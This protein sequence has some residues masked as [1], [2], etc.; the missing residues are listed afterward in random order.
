MLCAVGSGE[1][2]S[3]NARGSIGRAVVWVRD[4]PL[5]QLAAWLGALA[6]ALTAPFGGWADASHPPMT[7]V[8][9]DQVVKT[10]PIDVTITR[11]R[12]NT[13]PGETFAAMDDGQYL[14][15]FGTARGT[16]KTTLTNGE[17]ADAIRL[18]G[19]PGLEDLLH[20]RL[21]AGHEVDVGQAHGLCGRGLDVDDGVGPRPDLQVAWVWRQQQRPTEQ[22]RRA[23]QGF[24]WRQRSL[25]DYTGWLDP[26]PTAHLRLPVEVDPVGQAG[27]HTEPRGIAHAGGDVM[28]AADVCAVGSGRAAAWAPE[29]SSWPAWPWDESSPIVSRRRS[30]I[31]KPIER[32]GVIGAPIALRIGDVTVT[33][34][35][36][37]TSWASV[38]EGKRTQGVWLAA[39][40]DLLPSRRESGL[41]YAAVRDSSGHVWEL[42]RGESTC[43]AP[44]AGVPMH[45]Q[46]LIELPR[47]PISNA[48]LVLRWTNFDDRFDDQAVL[49]LTLDQATIDTWAGTEGPIKVPLATLG[50]S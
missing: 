50:D 22:H 31:E 29:S 4:R 45:C 24:T 30:V 9:T 41:S 47:R 16:A 39:S 2:R 6:L 34:V 46:V 3:D 23:G 14:L 19:V 44:I 17:L 42:G 12:A 33:E 37:A 43:K 25:D 15:V 49:P 5:K 13:R 36:G 1:G 10:G 18:D 20:Q 38:S 7:V 28:S 35:T 8:T 21:P 48:E 26:T 32:R 27:R 11:I 40:I